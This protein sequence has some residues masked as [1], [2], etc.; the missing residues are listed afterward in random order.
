MG[1][2]LER[3][4]LYL[5]SAALGL[6]LLEV[7]LDDFRNLRFRDS[8]SEDLEPGNVLLERVP[9]ALHQLLVELLELLDDDLEQCVVPK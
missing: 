1:A 4:K 5:K 2:N 3:E 6:L 9:Q 8:D 7:L